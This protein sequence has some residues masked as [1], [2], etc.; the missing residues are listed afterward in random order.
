M[1]DVR[2]GEEPTVDYRDAVHVA[3]VPATA[4]EML[5]P[6]Q[7]VGMIDGE[8][9]TNSEVVGIV[10]PYLT[11]VVPKG[12]KFW[13]CLL[14]GSVT[15][16]RHHWS[17]PLFDDLVP[18]A[19]QTKLDSEVW[20]QAY[21]SRMNS[22]DGGEEAFMRLCQG[23]RTRCLHANGTDLHALYELDDSEEL[24]RHAENYLGIDIE[25]QRFEFTCSC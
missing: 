16:M 24:K 12:G 22:Y 11:D 5:R 18:F 9:A 17:H 15:G 21:A 14:P 10:D 7:R 13:L 6:G 20:L 8:V 4:P 25:W 2:L 23:L 19:E 3:V 1:S